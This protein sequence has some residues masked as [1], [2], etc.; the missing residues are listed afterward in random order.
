MGGATT[1]SIDFMEPLIN[2]G[3]VQITIGS[4]DPERTKEG[5]SDIQIDTN[6]GKLT[7]LLKT[8]VMVHSQHF[9]KS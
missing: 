8:S 6:L 3:D 4:R 1:K 7:F 5:F 2:Q 9:P